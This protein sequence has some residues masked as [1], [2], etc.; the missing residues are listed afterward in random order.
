[1]RE[2]GG[3]GTDSGLRWRGL[4]S[5][6]PVWVSWADGLEQE[7]DLQMMPCPP[8]TSFSSVRY[9]GAAVVGEMNSQTKHEPGMTSISISSSCDAVGLC[10]SGRTPEMKR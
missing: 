7:V 8:I 5:E 4:G 3:E 1:M 6:V 2:G 9:G 10:P